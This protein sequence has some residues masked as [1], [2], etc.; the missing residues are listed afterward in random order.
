MCLGA[1]VA[2]CSG[3]SGLGFSRILAGFVNYFIKQ[4]IAPLEQPVYPRN[5]F[6]HKPANHIM[7]DTRPF[8]KRTH[9]NALI[10]IDVV[11]SLF[12][13]CTVLIPVSKAFLAVKRPFQEPGI[14]RDCARRWN[15]LAI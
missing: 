15:P 14:G 11:H 13:F 9:I 2:I 3:L 1:F 6:S 7:A 10:T 12:G 4:I 5:L 8:V